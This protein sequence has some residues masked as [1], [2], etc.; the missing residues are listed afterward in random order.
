MFRALF[1]IK[2]ELGSAYSA[3]RMGLHVWDRVT[4]HRVDLCWQQLLSHF[5]A[6]G[7]YGTLI[8]VIAEKVSSRTYIVLKS[9]NTLMA[10]CKS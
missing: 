8:A 6:E 7:V 5:E 1:Y 4:H 2:N 3:G 10:S 9:S